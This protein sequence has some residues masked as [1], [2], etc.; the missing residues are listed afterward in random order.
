MKDLNEQ[1][2]T[3]LR[4]AGSHGAFDVVAFSR[5]CV[6][7]IQCKVEKKSPTSIISRYKKY[8]D[9]IDRIGLTELPKHAIVKELT[10]K[11]DRKKPETFLVI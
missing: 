5:E 10:V 11:V 2:F 8:K 4:T 9:D 3:T 6:M 7:F 1:G